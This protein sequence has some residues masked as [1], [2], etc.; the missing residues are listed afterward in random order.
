M[1]P[2]HSGDPLGSILGTMGSHWV[3]KMGQNRKNLP[4]PKIRI[5]DYPAVINFSQ[6][7]EVTVMA[8]NH[9][10]D[11]L[12]SIFG[13][14]GSHWDQKTGQNRKKLPC[15]KIRIWDYPAV[16]DF[17]QKMEVTVMGPNHCGDPQGSIL[18][19]ILGPIGSHF[20]R[21]KWKLRLW[22]TITVGTLWGPSWGKCPIGSKKWI[23]T[24]KNYHAPKF[25]FLTPPPPHGHQFF[26]KTGS[27][28][29]GAKSRWGPSRVHLQANGV[30]LGKQNGSKL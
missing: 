6:K 27:Y 1:V 8:P 9:G 19:P 2:N 24:V 30:P 28:G 14:M 20:F 10:G 22:H 23:K 4:C 5:F 15:P 13:P 11:P 16:M 26:A 7:L 21:K 25:E 18:W 3:Q 17:S 12:G 29:Y